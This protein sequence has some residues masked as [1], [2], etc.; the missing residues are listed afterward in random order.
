VLGGRCALE[1]LGLSADPGLATWLLE[2]RG[3]LAA[4]SSAEDEHT[5]R[6]L[7]RHLLNDSS[8]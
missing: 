8:K 1:Q 3:R 7:F 4:A 6:S 5:A 2:I